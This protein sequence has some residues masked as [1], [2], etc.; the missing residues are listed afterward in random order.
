MNDGE[1]VRPTLYRGTVDKD[2]EIQ[3]AAPTAPQRALFCSDGGHSP[4]DD[5]L[6]IDEGTGKKAK[7]IEGGARENRHGGNGMEGGRSR[8]RSKLDRRILSP[9]IRSISW[10]CWKRTPTRPSPI[11]PLFSSSFV[12]N[13]ICWE[14]RR[15]IKW[16]IWSIL[17]ISI[18]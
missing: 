14:K 6:H 9:K 1:L 18:S 11:P 3:E 7:P 16:N 17:S 12:R 10:W 13:F 8:G 4:P 2:G 5:G 15:L